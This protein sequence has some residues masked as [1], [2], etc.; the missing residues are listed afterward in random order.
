[1]LKDV[2]NPA[3]ESRPATQ[4][5]LLTP[6]ADK[7]ADMLFDLSN[8]CRRGGVQERDAVL[9]PMLIETLHTRASGLATDLR[10]HERLLKE[11]EG[12]E[13]REAERK[14]AEAIQLV[15]AC[16]P[17]L[18][19]VQLDRHCGESPAAAIER[20]IRSAF[21]EYDRQVFLDAGAD[22]FDEFSLRGHLGPGQVGRLALTLVATRKALVRRERE[23]A[24]E[25][26][27]FR[28]TQ[29]KLKKAAA[30]IKSLTA[31]VKQLKQEKPNV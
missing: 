10:Q 7:L 29:R 22:L 24:E 15:V 13:G 30:T 9:V 16:I 2:D 14:T 21:V 20:W 27:S 8:W 4:A 25:T 18:G 17:Y 1:M 26:T 12:V 31:E 19:A 6:A 3:P 11:M 5:P 23:L 28:R